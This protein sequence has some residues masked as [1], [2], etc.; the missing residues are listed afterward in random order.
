MT[1][2]DPSFDTEQLYHLLDS[3]GIEYSVLHHKPLRTVEDAKSIRAALESDEGQIKNLFLKNK[4]GEMWLLTLHEDREIHLKQAAMEIGAKRFSFCSAERLM[5]YLGV[6]PGAVSPFG[7]LNDV[8]GKVK[9][10]IDEG[11]LG[12]KMIHAHPMDNRIT[13]SI[14]TIDMLNFLQSQGHPYDILP[15]SFG[16]PATS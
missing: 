10:Y 1:N 12:H 16:S 8:E 5:R 2:P 7:L 9:F 15:S 3:S 4:K 6:V 14:G 11:L 13:V